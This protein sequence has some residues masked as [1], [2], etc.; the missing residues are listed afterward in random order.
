[1]A[2]AG[3]PLAA[4]PVERLQ[5]LPEATYKRWAKQAT[6]ALKTLNPATRDI[7]AVDLNNL[8]HFGG[9]VRAYFGTDF[10][11]FNR[12]QFVANVQ[13]YKSTAV[14]DAFKEFFDSAD[15]FHYGAFQVIAPLGLQESLRVSSAGDTAPESNYTA[16]TERNDELMRENV[17][18][19]AERDAAHRDLAATQV[20]LAREREAAQRNLNA[21]R[22][23]FTEELRHLTAARDEANTALASVTA[24]R[25]NANSL[26]AYA[27]RTLDSFSEEH[28][29]RWKVER[30][31]VP[32]ACVA[33][34]ACAILRVVSS[35]Q[36]IRHT[37]ALVFV[38]AV[39]LIFLAFNRTRYGAVGILLT[40]CAMY[41]LVADNALTAY[42]S[43]T[44]LG[45]VFGGLL[46]GA[47]IMFGMHLWTRSADAR[48]DL[49]RQT[50]RAATPIPR[51]AAT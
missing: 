40:T 27:R 13:R 45:F 33:L 18:T 41:L 49:A 51:P 17:Q 14:S 35:N 32:L 6:D 48:E 34:I 42:V 19:K 46:V 2:D 29:S 21:M 23:T 24:E 50:M 37:V 1:M 7:N 36:L 30:A 47:V 31:F 44:V 9:E 5:E 38:L 4:R 28:Q 43:D 26:L 39:A 8:D 10:D 20:L 22:R 11:L 25:D 12:D 15:P 16:L 3:A